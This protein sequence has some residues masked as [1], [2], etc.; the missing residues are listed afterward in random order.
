MKKFRK[1]IIIIVTLFLTVYSLVVLYATNK[2]QIRINKIIEL[3]NKE[4]KNK[5]DII[6][7]NYEA[8]ANIVY[9]NQVNTPEI[10]KLI[11]E[12]LK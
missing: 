5:M 10:T 12:A 3:E 8:I 4:I 11:Y 6:L 7:N 1:K 2:K 9:E